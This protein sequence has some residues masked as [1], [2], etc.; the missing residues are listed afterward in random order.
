VITGR[1]IGGTVATY[2]WYCP[3]CGREDYDYPEDE[4]PTEPRVCSA[5]GAEL[6]KL[7]AEIEQDSDSD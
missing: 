6:C 2:H 1:R 5:C 7:D 4:E 3:D